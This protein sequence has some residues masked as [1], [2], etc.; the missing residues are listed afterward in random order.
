MKQSQGETTLPP[1]TTTTRKRRKE[2]QGGTAGDEVIQQTQKLRQSRKS[3]TFTKPAST[4]RSSSRR[5]TTRTI[6]K[7]NDTEMSGESDMAAEPVSGSDVDPHLETTVTISKGTGRQR[8]SLGKRP[9]RE[10]TT[11][12]LLEVEESSEGHKQLGTRVTSTATKKKN[13]KSIPKSTMMVSPTQPVVEDQPL[14]SPFIN[15]EDDHSD[16]LSPMR[17]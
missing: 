9:P 16:R 5:T 4:A 8:K 10:R 13:R 11:K 15:G 1:A 14:P 17:T 12:R 7:E 2:Q 6:H 3:A